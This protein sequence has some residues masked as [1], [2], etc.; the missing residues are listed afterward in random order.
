M[1]GR[2]RAESLSAEL[3]R[4]GFSSGVTPLDRYFQEQVS[5]D[6]R[7]RV[8]ACYVAIEADTS[9]IAGYYTLTAGSIPLAD[10]PDSLARRLSRYQIVPVARLAVELSYRG[11]KL[12]GALLWDAMIRA[13]RS[14][15][16]VF[17]LV[18]DAK[19][20]QAA[21]FYQHHGFMAFG[22]LPHQL[23]LPLTNRTLGFNT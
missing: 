9:R 12:G 20:D 14:E 10:V 7:R 6:I 19:D 11:Q 17:A 15:V 22:S 8:T 21:A 23:I 16:A 2:F 3:D 5:Q 4:S 1:T 13:I 18:V